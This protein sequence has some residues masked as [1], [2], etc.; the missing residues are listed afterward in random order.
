MAPQ[1]LTDELAA[2]TGF[3]D[4]VRDWVRGT[5]IP[6]GLVRRI[7]LNN[8]KQMVSSEKSKI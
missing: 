1:V 3:G 4:I 6:N 2:Q 7:T 8:A 5:S